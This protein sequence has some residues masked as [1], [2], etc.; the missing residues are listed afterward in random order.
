MIKEAV[1]QDVVYQQT[2][3]Q[4]QLSNSTEKQP[5]YAL[6]AARLLYYKGRLYVPD[7][8]NIKNLI[9]DEYHRSH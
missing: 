2:K 9:M 4:V 5:D 3:Q 8:N 7:Q 1:K 6:D